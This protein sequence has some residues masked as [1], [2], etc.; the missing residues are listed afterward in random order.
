[1]RLDSFV[2]FLVNEAQKAVEPQ[3]DKRIQKLRTGRGYG[4]TAASWPR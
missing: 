1:M 4:F 3:K 2:P